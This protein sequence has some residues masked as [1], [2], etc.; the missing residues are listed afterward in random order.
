MA[1]HRVV[2]WVTTKTNTKSKKSSAGVTRPWVLSEIHSRLGTRG[3]SFRTV[4]LMG[5]SLSPSVRA[6]SRPPGH[7]VANPAIERGGRNATACLALLAVAEGKGLL[8]V[9]GIQIN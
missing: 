2:T 7:P 4:L 8:A 6:D 1:L 9:G 3:V 5:G